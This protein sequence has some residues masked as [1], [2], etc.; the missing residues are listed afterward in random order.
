MQCDW[1]VKEAPPEG[2]EKSERVPE[3]RQ[4]PRREW[5]QPIAMFHLKKFTLLYGHVGEMTTKTQTRTHMH[6]QMEQIRQGMT[7]K[8]VSEQESL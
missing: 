3:K 8:R 1:L 7:E 5:K 2:V 4:K 6:T